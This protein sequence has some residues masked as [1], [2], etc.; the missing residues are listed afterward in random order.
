VISRPKSKPVLGLDV[1]ASSVKL[2]ELRKSG[3][4][5]RV[6]HFAVEP[7]PA[8]AISDKAI[9]DIE[10]VGE[11]VGRAW[12]RSGTRLKSAAIAIGGANVIIKTLTIPAG[13]SDRESEEQVGLAAAKIVPFAM[14]D[15][16]WDFEL[17]GPSASE[18]GMQEA[19]LVATRRENVEHRQAALEI[20]GLKTEVVDCESFALENAFPLLNGHDATSE[21]KTLVAMFDFGSTTTTLSVLHDGHIIYTR[22]QAFGGSQLTAEIMR[23]Y[24]LS[25]ED[26][27]RAKR[28]GGLPE[29]YQTE[30]LGPFMDSMA[31]ETA[32]S[33]QFFYAAMSEYAQVDRVLV[34]GGCAAIPG[35]AEVI[36]KHLGVATETANP[37][38]GLELGG[39][40][41]AQGV[42]RDA[43]A[44]MIA[45]GLALRSF[46]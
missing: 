34:S 11:A 36:G 13:L 1:S 45:C 35:V 27:G 38:A 24:E 14:D 28:R 37:L 32:R 2:V 33:L 17:I 43:P 40:A 23:V 21:N 16:S 9:T 46:Q 18:S 4:S 15:V 22:D 25:Y 6:A 41:R 29:S 12:K 39:R 8:N 7:T 42:E 44:L 10:A 31:R 20:A 30:V 5:Y 3:I 26:A 19:L